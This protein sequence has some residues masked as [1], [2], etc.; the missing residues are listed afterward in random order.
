[1][2]H[3]YDLQF[4]TSP[5][6]TAERG[7]RAL[8]SSNLDVLFDH[9]VD[10][11]NSEPLPPFEFETVLL[12]HGS[13]LRPWLLQNLADRLGCAAGLYTPTIREFA[14]SIIRSIFGVEPSA[15]DRETL[16]WRIFAELGDTSADSKLAPIHNY[17]QRAG[18]ERMLLARRLA[19]LF[20][21][22]QTYRPDM[23]ARW[24]QG[25]VGSGAEEW[26]A[27]LWRRVIRD[28]DLP[29]HRAAL[30]Q[31]LIEYLGED[32]PTD[33]SARIS[34]FGES[35]LAPIQLRFLD[36]LSA[37]V[38]IVWYI[39][40]DA[41]R[42]PSHSL[43]DVHGEDA[44]EADALRQKY[45]RR[46]SVERIDGRAKPEQVSALD[47]IQDDIRHGRRRSGDDR[48][49]IS[50][51]DATIRI[52]N[53]HSP[54]RELEVLRDQ[55]LDAFKVLEGLEPSDILIVVPD[56]DT[57]A[58]LVEAVFS[59]GDEA[60]RLP[61]VVARDP[62]EAG[63]RYLSSFLA[64]LEAMTSRLAAGEILELLSEP[65]VGR[66]AHIDADEIEV[67][68]TWIRSTHIR[69][70]AD[71][72]HRIEFGLPGDDLHTWRHG[73]DRLLMGLVAGESDDPVDGVI[74]LSEATFDR[75]ELL[76]RFAS[77][78]DAFTEASHNVRRTR[79]LEDW[80][81]WLLEFVPRFV[82]AETDDERMAEDHLLAELRDME[83][84][85]PDV[86]IDFASVRS[87]LTSVLDRFEGRGKL[88]SGAITV[89][90]YERLR[91][92]PAR[93]V[94][95]VGLSDDAFPRTDAA[96]DFDL[97][98]SARREGDP[99][100]RRLDKQLFLDVLQACRDR[101]ILTYVG[102]S[103]RDNSERAPSI[104]I[105]TLLQTLTSTFTAGHEDREDDTRNVRRHFVV[106]HPL[107]PFSTHYFDGS[108][109]RLFSYDRTNCIPP[110]DALARISAFASGALPQEEESDQ[111]ITLDDL[112]AAWINPSKFYCRRLGLRLDLA[113]LTIEDIEPQFLDSL[114]R[115]NLKDA[116]LQRLL[117]GEPDEQ[118]RR[119]LQME[120]ALPAGALGRIVYTN[121]RAEIEP[122]LRQVDQF[123]ERRPIEIDLEVA[124]RRII[125]RIPYVTDQ[126]SLHFRPAKV[127]PKDRLSVWIYHLS[128]AASG[129]Q[130]PSRLIATDE[131][132]HIAHVEDPLAYLEP[133][134][135]RY[136]DILRE[137]LML[138][139]KSSMRFSERENI[140]DARRGF[141][142]GY[143]TRGDCDDH[144]VRFLNRHHHPIEDR[145]EDFAREA[146]E[147]WGPINEHLTKV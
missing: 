76:G 30:M 39:V 28:A 107:Q 135:K 95:C 57:Y 80:R 7:V 47:I 111:P 113:D 51:E 99:D 102:R 79:S 11:I 74:P 59:A 1:M 35:V 8:K 25:K 40:D 37:H 91:F 61:A 84:H 101:L 146:R 140:N 92:I 27:R 17:L 122:L 121:E 85:T 18:D 23:I 44:R 10:R 13:A 70:G 31:Q 145:L 77:W 116:I 73:L 26:Q 118:V 127:K 2:D 20:E 34:I 32:R 137:P 93:V 100:Q 134:V 6:R 144:Y 98:A 21:T 90:D 94:A 120:G 115:Y 81:D 52:H 117:D 119:R 54:T 69:W 143:R 83:Q 68:R 64:L 65:A 141:D 16:T 108:D 42:E 9:F 24:S 4:P 96:P 14:G 82:H 38:D 86:E 138:F 131:N 124:G 19:Q 41:S 43:F 97:I 129:M 136:D 72:G 109:P 55:L 63:R 22:Y 3:Q 12:P 36:A 106:E 60:Q 66:R 50:R 49:E 53:C 147:L 89:A 48:V 87:Y 110:S 58:P 45:L 78:M 105:D 133:L 132:Q 142:G 130:R 139:P 75:A 104:I 62:R 103:Q 46:A 88:L 33:L 56:L 114:E 67:I 71:G 128:L 29:T 5:P 126:V 125:G 112:I 15:L 123:G